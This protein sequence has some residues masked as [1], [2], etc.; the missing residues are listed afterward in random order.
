MVVDLFAALGPGGM[1]PGIAMMLA[2]TVWLIYVSDR[3]HDSRRRDPGVL[4]TRHHFH[5]DHGGVLLSLAGIACAASLILFS[6]RIPQ[7]RIWSASAVSGG[8][9]AG[10]TRPGVW[11]LAGCAGF[12]ALAWFPGRSALWRHSKNLVAACTFANGTALGAYGASAVDVSSPPVVCAVA[13]FAMLCLMNLNAIDAWESG[14]NAV[15]AVPGTT[16]SLLVPMAALLPVSVLSGITSSDWFFAM[17]IWIAAAGLWVVDRFR[18][19]LSASALRV[20]ADVALVVPLFIAMS[21]EC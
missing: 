17:A 4:G 2:A 11:V 1:D 9:W 12:A 6:D 18:A 7:A 15:S 10:A 21:L 8:W 5:R 19:R 3:W 20:L 16:P 13:G 14:K